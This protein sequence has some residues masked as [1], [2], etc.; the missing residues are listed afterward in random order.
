MKMKKEPF[1]ALLAFGRA[2]VV[3]HGRNSKGRSSTTYLFNN[4]IFPYLCRFMYKP[5]R[6]G[7][8][9]SVVPIKKVSCTLNNDYEP[10]VFYWGV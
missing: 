2:T 7:V 4:R 9:L 8:M 6:N 5:S 10:I 1:S 3:L